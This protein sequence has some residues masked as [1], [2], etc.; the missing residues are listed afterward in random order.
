MSSWEFFKTLSFVYG[1]FLL[2]EST[3]VFLLPR[4]WLRVIV[5][6]YPEKRPKWLKIAFFAFILFSAFIAYQ[7]FIRIS[8]WALFPFL[9]TLVILITLG[10]MFFQYREFRDLILNMILIDRNV[11]AVVVFI[12]G[13]IALLLLALACF[14]F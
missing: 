6:L 4:L 11:L 13:V 14:G 2:G 10:E 8:F 12:E 9:F 5:A 1:L 7:F 3:F